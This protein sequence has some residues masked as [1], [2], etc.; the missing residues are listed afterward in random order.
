FHASFSMLKKSFPSSLLKCGANHSKLALA[1]KGFSC[2]FILNAGFLGK[3]SKKSTFCVC[4]IQRDTHFLLEFTLLDV[5][6]RIN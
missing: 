4:F 3:D 2:V 5:V 1:V 6:K